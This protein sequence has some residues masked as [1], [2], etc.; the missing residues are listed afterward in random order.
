M[1]TPGIKTSEFWVTLVATL[2][3]MLLVMG[4]IPHAPEVSSAVEAVCVMLSAFGYT[5]FRA[6]VKTKQH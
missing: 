4:V 5:A 3:N 2:F 1:I 6:F